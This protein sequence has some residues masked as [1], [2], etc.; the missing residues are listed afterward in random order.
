M[1]SEKYS[2]LMGSGLLAKVNLFQ[3]PQQADEIFYSLIIGERY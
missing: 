3:L 1:S 2:I